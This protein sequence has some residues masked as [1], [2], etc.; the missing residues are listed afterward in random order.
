MTTVRSS[1]RSDSAG[2]ADSC[3]WSRRPRIP[4]LP[5]RTARASTTG[6]RHVEAA[7]REFD[8][9]LDLITVESV[10]TCRDVVKIRARFEV[11][12]DRGDRHACVPKHLGPTDFAGNTLDG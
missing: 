8:H 5:D 9:G 3:R 2:R 10:V 11:L 1:V 6:R 12:K 7:R 4:E